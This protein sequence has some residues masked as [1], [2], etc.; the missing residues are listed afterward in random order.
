MPRQGS[1]ATILAAL[2]DGKPKTHRELV[3]AT[4]LSDA[5]VWNAL[6]RAWRDGLVMRTEKPAYEAVK[7]FRGR[8]GVSKTTRTF[9][10]YL[11]APKGE[12]RVR[13]GDLEF[14]AFSKRYLDARGGG[15]RSKAKLIL[16]FLQKHAD[17][18]WY[19]KQVAEALKKYGVRSVDVMSNV[20]RFER[21]GLVYVRGYRTD[22]RQTPFA[23]GFLLTWIDSNKP[24]ERALSE[25]VE[26]T[27]RMLAG[28]ISTSPIIER[29]HQIRDTIIEA[30]KLRELTSTEFLKRKLT[31][32]DNEAEHAIERALQ[33]YPDLKEVK[34]FGAYRYFYHDS[35]DEADLKAAIKMKE[36]YIRVTKGRANRVGHNWEACVEWFVDKFTYGAHFWTQQHRSNMDPKRIT[37]HLI[38]PVSGR[39]Q[40]AEVD[41]VWEVSQGL[42]A[43]PITYVLECKWGLVHKRDLDDFVNILRWSKEFGVD[44][45]DGRM[46]KQ[47]VV[48]IFASG[49]FD[50]KE[51][52]HLKNEVIDLASYAGRLNVQL[53][54]E[55]DFNQ[56]LR[57]RGC[58]TTIGRICRLAAN[59][60]QVRDAMDRIWNEPTKADGILSELMEKNKKLYEFE[61][62]LAS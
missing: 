55:A 18:A 20:R 32:S 58:E 11:L 28:E 16:Q 29:V 39:R 14:V 9:H 62:M 50:P 45:Q 33:L 54:K 19:S 4:G 24:R 51:K 60:V 52:V 15:S 59:E 43:K 1:Q 13:L 12:K 17:K 30:T 34:L 46:I 25:A 38:K 40:A 5:A 56:K 41:R 8:A 3:R 27:S 22:S 6:A 31:C 57:E 35:M 44:T 53:L 36:N 7:F 42:L 47:G 61:R 23:Q 48:G 21:K 49:A 26:R 10:Q 37:L 2:A